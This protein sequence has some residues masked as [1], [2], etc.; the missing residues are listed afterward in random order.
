MSE[1]CPLTTTRF[2][3]QDFIVGVCDGLALMIKVKFKGLHVFSSNSRK[4][5]RKDDTISGVGW[6]LWQ[7]IFKI[8]LGSY[9]CCYSPVLFKIKLKLLAALN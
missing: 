3:S 5:N 9:C 7:N 2:K 6:T 1:N 4:L 8:F